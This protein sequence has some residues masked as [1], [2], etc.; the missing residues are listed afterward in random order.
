[1]ID[2]TVSRAAMLAD[3]AR[4]EAWDN[5]DGNAWMLPLGALLAANGVNIVPPLHPADSNR[6][7]VK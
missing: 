5:G 4:R 3:I 2:R 1:P 7:T 6:K